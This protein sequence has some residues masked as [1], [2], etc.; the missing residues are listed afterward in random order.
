MIH[1]SLNQS[2]KMGGTGRKMKDGR[3]EEK[4]QRNLFIGHNEYVIV[5]K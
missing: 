4:D 3:I 2:K 5:V 1:C